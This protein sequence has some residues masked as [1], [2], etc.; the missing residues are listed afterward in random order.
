MTTMISNIQTTRLEMHEW[1]ATETDE[2]MVSEVANFAADL[3]IE[4]AGMDLKPMSSEEYKARL[5]KSRQDYLEGRYKTVNQLK[6]Q[7]KNW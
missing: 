6:E 1:L 5:A 4:V 3:K 2:N 7:I